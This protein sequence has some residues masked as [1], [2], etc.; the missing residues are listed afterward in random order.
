MN[1]DLNPKENDTWQER[2]P[3]CCKIE[4]REDLVFVYPIEF[5]GQVN[6]VADKLQLALARIFHESVLN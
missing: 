2:Y 1:D 4:Q 3:Y 5:G 6:V